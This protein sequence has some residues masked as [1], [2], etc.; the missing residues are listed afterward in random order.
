MSGNE[1]KHVQTELDRDEYEAFREFARERGLTVKEAG[2]EALVSW[3]ERQ[4]GADPNDRAF[5]VLDDLDS[6]SAA[7]ETDARQEADLVDEWTGDDVAVT[8]ADEP[9]TGSDDH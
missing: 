7:T 1:T 5:T 6:L 3:I 8:L 2:H 4:R 9:P